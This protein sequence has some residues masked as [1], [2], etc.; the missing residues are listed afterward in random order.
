MDNSLYTR[1]KGQTI[2]Q[3]TRSCVI[4]KDGK[5]YRGGKEQLGIPE[6]VYF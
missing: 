3:E 2:T 6:G 1:W 5:R 4:Y